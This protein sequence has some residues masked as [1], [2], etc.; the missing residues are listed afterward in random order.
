MKTRCQM[1]TLEKMI[2]FHK[3][4]ENKIGFDGWI[5]GSNPGL[6]DCLVL[7]NNICWTTHNVRD[8]EKMLKKD[9]VSKL[10]SITWKKYI[11]KV[12]PCNSNLL[13]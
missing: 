6:G 7:S 12:Q 5:Y 2:L 3:L 9:N 1:I 8:C 10:I 4:N 13:Y 11:L